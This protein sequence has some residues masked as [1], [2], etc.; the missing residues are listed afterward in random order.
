LRRSHGSTHPELDSE[1][2][3]PSRYYG[4]SA[5]Q[6]GRWLGSGFG[7]VAQGGVVD[8][9]AFSQLLLGINPITGEALISAAGSAGRAQRTRSTSGLLPN[10]VT[11]DSRL[12]LKTA[13]EFLGLDRSYVRKLIARTAATRAAGEEVPSVFLD[14]EK[15]GPKRSWEVSVA[16]LQRFAGAREAQ[17]VVLGYDVTFSCPKSVSLLWA[18]VDPDVRAEILAAIEASVAAGIAYLEENGCTVRAG[19]TAA[20]DGLLAAGFLHATSRALDPQLH[21][22]CVV[23]N[24][25]AGPS[26]DF[27][28]LYSPHLFAH[29]KT[30]GYLAGARLRHE[31]TE[32]LGV[33]WEASVNGLADIEGIDRETIQAFSKRSTEIGE[34]AEAAGLRTA[35][36]RQSAALSTRSAKQAVDAGE[37]IDGWHHELTERGYDTDRVAGLLSREQSSGIVAEADLE[38][39]SQELLSARGLTELHAVFDRRDVIQRIAEWAGDRLSAAGV[40]DIAD[41]FLTQPEVVLLGT[42]QAGRPGSVIHRAD[43]RTIRTGTGPTYTTQSMLRVESK[44]R[45]QFQRGLAAGTATVPD[46]LIERAIASQ[47]SLG[48]DQQ[49]MVRSICRSGDRVQCVLGP[50]GSGKTFALEV[51]TRAW[52]AN[53]QRVIGVAVAGVAAEVL[54]R[55]IGIETTTVAAMLTRLETAGPSGLLDERTV[56]LVDEAST[57]G[58]R[59]L[60]R[61][62]RWTDETGAAV[63][64]IGDPAQ[65]SAV[66]AGGMFRHLVEEHPGR[67]PA[68]TVNRRQAGESMGQVRLALSEYRDGQI[69]AALDRLERDDRVVTAPNADE[70]LDAL[71]A[72]WYVDRQQRATDPSLAASAMVAE[73]H[74]ERAELNERARAL[75]VDDGTIHGDALTA[76]GQEFQAGDE[77]ICRAQDKSLRPVDGNRRSYIRNGTRGTVVSAHTDDGRPGLVVDFAARG[78]VFV[79]SDFLEAEVRRGVIGGLTHAYALTSHAAQG[80][81]Y[82]S[83][84]HLATDQS[85][86]EGVYVGLTRGRSDVR[87]YAVSRSDL[88][89]RIDDDPGLPKLQA[90]TIEAREAVANRL[91]RL[92]GERLASEQDGLGQAAR[93]MRDT[94]TP[95]EL[96]NVACSPGAHP[97]AVRAW[98]AAQAR[99]AAEARV[100]PSVEAI[101]RIGPRPAP[102]ASR[103]RWDT[104]AA[105]LAEHRI[106]HS[107]DRSPESAEA[108]KA[109]EAV[110][111]A[112]KRAQ[113]TSQTP[114]PGTAPVTPEDFPSAGHSVVALPKISLER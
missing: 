7:S 9:D 29:A 27:G 17:A 75:L 99:I 87:L 109:V 82:E 44:I 41:D 88:V 112:A 45:D 92:S 25:T 56:V 76:A 78:E 31:L 79:P 108:W 2:D 91:S 89:P 4:D 40:A 102:G 43:G 26:G 60:G 48:G 65:H 72:D 97:D 80:E 53:E 113:S 51:A 49:A 96:H 5:E 69:A 16:E 38:R 105:A 100:R 101:E 18:M 110:I 21:W 93:Q 42:S 62:L 33:A 46:R 107:P 8:S 77:V 50:A 104:A 15:T 32:R 66:A 19:G 14:G 73:H 61:L 23:I 84:R 22:H 20:G 83:G 37:L 34:V 111:D 57:L 35:A 98:E 12:G 86:R 71:V 47:P 106:V 67:V 90:E 64:L 54:S 85:S 10:G 103:L 114:V 55:S 36:G 59:D 13:S 28:A 95:R 63:R 1:V 39:L 58:T 52:E 30:A 68:L 3:A 70:L 6:A 74:F 24:A 81:T 94:L 11:A